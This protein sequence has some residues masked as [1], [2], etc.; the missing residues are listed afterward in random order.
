MQKV[1]KNIEPS[2]RT[3]LGDAFCFSIIDDVAFESGWVYDKYIHLEYTP[4]DGQIKYAG[5]DYYDFV[6]DQGVF[7]KSYIEYPYIHCNKDIVCNQIIQMID[8]NEY[9]FALWNETV[10]TNYLFQENSN[11]IYEH[12]CFLYGYDREKEVFYTQGY[13]DNYRWEH[14]SI[15]FEVYYKAVSYCS[16]KEEIAFIGYKL[17]ED[18][19][20]TF[21]LEK[22]RKQLKLYIDTSFQNH[23]ENNCDM[24]AILNFY[25]NLIVGKKIHYP[26]LYCIYEHKK[27]FANRISFLI[28]K[29]MIKEKD[30]LEQAKEL[31]KISRKILLFGIN[32]NSN[33]ATEMFDVIYNE[34][35]KM[36]DLEAKL[37]L[38]IKTL[39]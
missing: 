24:G 18:Y 38:K 34:V 7:I 35:E 8:N 22:I 28:E 25:S 30:V 23:K 27:V 39:L 16:Q 19:N 36:L 2:I 31:E 20:W 26:S 21:D 32:Y 5:Y 15:P 11:I 3:Y 4:L 10:V 14:F 29:G 6:P 33:L 12:G 17:K 13:L 9:C 37:L 1:L